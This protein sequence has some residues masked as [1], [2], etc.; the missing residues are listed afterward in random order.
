MLFA[1][2]RRGVFSLH[3]RRDA[4]LVHFASYTDSTVWQV[5]SWRDILQPYSTQ[6]PQTGA[7]PTG[8]DRHPPLK[9]QKQR[10]NER[11]RF[12]GDTTDVE[13]RKEKGDQADVVTS[14]SRRR[15][16][17]TTST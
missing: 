2:A 3:L 7:G 8:S 5:A 4:L 11:G 1:I 10:E 13:D 17:I 16:G 15:K 12:V 9:E 14:C 6:R